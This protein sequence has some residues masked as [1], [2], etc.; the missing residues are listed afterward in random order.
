VTSCD[1]YRLLSQ[2]HTQKAEQCEQ[3]RRRRAELH[4][5]IGNADSEAHE[6]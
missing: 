1:V 6:E 2:N 3:R 5:A 4:K